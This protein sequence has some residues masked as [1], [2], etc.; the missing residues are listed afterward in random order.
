MNLHHLTG[1]YRVL[2]QC[3]REQA[4]DFE[5]VLTDILS[6]TRLLHLAGVGQSGRLKKLADILKDHQDIMLSISINRE[7]A[8]WGISEFKDILAR[9]DVLFVDKPTLEEL[10]GKNWR[11]AARMCRATGLRCLVL[12]LGYGEKEVK[13]KKKNSAACIHTYIQDAEYECVIESAVRKWPGTVDTTG[14]QDTFAAGYLYGLLSG[15]PLEKRG[16]IGDIMAQACLKDFGVR[17]SL[18]DPEE[19]TARYSQIHREELG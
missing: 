4:I 14:V 3:H 18:P 12:F 19:V 17:D 16:F 8:G 5:S 7:E 1:H 13:I 11:K 15:F 2:F 6:K 9:A 10:T